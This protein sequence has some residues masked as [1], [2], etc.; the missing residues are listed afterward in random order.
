LGDSELEQTLAPLVG[1]MQAHA[2]SSVSK[3]SPFSV[4]QVQGSE[5]LLLRS[6]PG[7][8]VP[9]ACMGSELEPELSPVPDE[10]WLVLDVGS[11]VP[12][13][14]LPGSYLPPQAAT[15][16]LRAKSPTASNE[17]RRSSLIPRPIRITWCA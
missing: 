16:P 11:P 9:R 4:T 5:G 7:T 2:A 3:H 8:H 17:M 6:K 14:W 15:H 12:D 1:Q 13:F 10:L